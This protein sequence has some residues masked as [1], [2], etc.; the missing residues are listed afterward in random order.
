[1]AHRSVFRDV[2]ATT[3]DIHLLQG[4]QIKVTGSITPM[5]PRRRAS[6]PGEKHP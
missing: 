3:A 1:M 6:E 2:S 4:F 5:M